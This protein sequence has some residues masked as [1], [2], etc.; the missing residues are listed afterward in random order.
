[1]NLTSSTLTAAPRTAVADISTGTDALIVAEAVDPAALADIAL[2]ARSDG[3]TPIVPVA[4]ISPEWLSLTRTVIVPA[5]YVPNEV[6]AGNVC[7]GLHW[8]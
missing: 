7:L 8:L 3:R 2:G 6:P 5:G 4:L 1:M